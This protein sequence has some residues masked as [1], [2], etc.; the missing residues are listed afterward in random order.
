MGRA[1]PMSSAR[2]S[3]PDTVLVQ[4]PGGASEAEPPLSPFPEGWYFVASRSAIEQGNLL[5]RQWLGQFIIAWCNDEGAICVALSVCPHLGSSLG[6]AAG[7]RVRDGLLICPF[8]GFAYDAAGNCVVTPNAPPPKNA[9]LSVLETREYLGLVFAWWGIDGRTAQW[10]L[11][12]EPP[13]DGWSGLELRT[14]QFPGHPQEMAEN[15][16]DL[17]HL[18]YVHLYDDVNAVDAPVVDGS[19]LVSRYEFSRRRRIVAGIGLEYEISIT[20]HV[21]GLGYSL[22]EIREHTIG[23]N[24]RMWAL[25]TPIDGTLVDLLLVSQL[26]RLLKPR[27][28]IA[29]LGFLPVGLRTVLMNKFMVAMQERDVR[30]DI[31]IWNRKQYLPH[32]TPVPLRRPDRPVPALLPAVLSGSQSHCALIA[33]ARM[34]FVVACGSRRF[35]EAAR[36][37]AGS[38]EEPGTGLEDVLRRNAALHRERSLSRRRRRLRQL[39]IRSRKGRVPCP[40]GDTVPTRALRAMRRPAAADPGSLSVRAKAAGR[41]LGVL[42]LPC[43]SGHMAGHPG[44]ALEEGPATDIE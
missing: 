26:E 24:C 38:S 11:P 39:R 7:G 3:W 2:R 25:A 40:C 37:G 6:P 5:E 22:I 21:H 28:P 29:G 10:D 42:R 17:G 34:R 41:V 33:G 31:V 13:I 14:L 1:R 36:E 16:V 27:R 20:I 44:A 9:R 4:F 19:E 12:A 43:G 35:C 23:M 8:H 30:Q 18:R 32:P 15:A